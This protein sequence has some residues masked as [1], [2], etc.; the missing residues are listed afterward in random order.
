MLYFFSEFINIVSLSYYKCIE[1]IILLYNF[2]AILLAR[3]KDYI[4]V[5]DVLH[6]FSGAS[7]IANLWSICIGI[8]I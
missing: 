4:D 3:Y 6:G 5:S 2:R 7:A 1:F 8:N